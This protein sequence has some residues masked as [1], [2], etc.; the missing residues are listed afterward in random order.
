MCMYMCVYINLHYPQY[1]PFHPMI[2]ACLLAFLPTSPTPYTPAV[3][4][5]SLGLSFTRATAAFESE[6]ARR[7][8][9]KIRWALLGKHQI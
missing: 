7:S 4:L 1:I 3:E 8:G 9:T 2:A 6:A 5:Y